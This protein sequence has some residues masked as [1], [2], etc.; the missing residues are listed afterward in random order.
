MIKYSLFRS[1]HAAG[2]FGVFLSLLLSTL[3]VSVPALLRSHQIEI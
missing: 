2:S 3:A 1:V